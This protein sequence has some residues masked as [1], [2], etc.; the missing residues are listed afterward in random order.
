MKTFY[1]LLISR[2]DIYWFRPKHCAEYLSGIIFSFSLSPTD[3][4]TEMSITEILEMKCG[5][6]YIE[7]VKMRLFPIFSLN[8]GHVHP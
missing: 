6:F 8:N 2:H 1:F 7:G 5:I 4:K 3:L